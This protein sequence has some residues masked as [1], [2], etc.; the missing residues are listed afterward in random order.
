MITNKTIAIT[1]GTG[2]FGNAVTA[3]LLKLKPKKIII[4]SRDELKQEI[5][6]NKYDNPLLD[7]VIGDIRDLDSIDKAMRGVDYVFH[8]AA[9]KQVPMCEVFPMEAVK[10]NVLGGANVIE[11]AI[12]NKVKRVVVL[13]TD[14]AVYPINV[15]GMSKALME[16]VMIARSKESKTILCGVRYGNVLYSRGSVLPYFVSLIQQG[17]QLQITDVS[18]TRF[19][20]TLSDA[21]DLVLETLVKGERG[22]IYVRRSPACTIIVLAQ[23]LCELFNVPNI[24]KVIGVKTGEKTHETLIAEENFTSENTKRLNVEQTKDLLLTIPEI[25]NILNETKLREER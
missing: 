1:G 8:A 17:K 9:F 6:R 22:Q 4:F 12:K 11:S 3:R 13:T 7:F 23:A 2:S 14:K 5:M 21:V 16:K 25:A 10:T 19:L 15:M 18:M 20:L 24:Y